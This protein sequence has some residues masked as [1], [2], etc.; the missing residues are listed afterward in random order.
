MIFLTHA[1]IIN[2]VEALSEKRMSIF[3]ESL[4]VYFLHVF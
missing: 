2:A 1:E 3:V 4:Q